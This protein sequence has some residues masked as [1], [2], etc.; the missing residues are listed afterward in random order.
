M[1]AGLINLNTYKKESFLTW[2][3]NSSQETAPIGTYD[4]PLDSSCHVEHTGGMRFPEFSA[5]SE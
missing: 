1:Q 2:K 5:I 3:S 4:T